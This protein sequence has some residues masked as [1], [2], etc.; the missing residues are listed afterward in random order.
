MFL[1]GKPLTHSVD[2]CC[3]RLRFLPLL[4]G[5]GCADAGGGVGA[6]LNMVTLTLTPSVRTSLWKR[7]LDKDDCLLKVTQLVKRLHQYSALAVNFLQSSFDNDGTLT[8][9]ACNNLHSNP[10]ESQICQDAFFA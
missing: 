2:V 1:S 5:S 9:I 3:C 7:R 6:G 10:L 4:G 8:P